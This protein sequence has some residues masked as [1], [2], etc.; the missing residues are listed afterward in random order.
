MDRRKFINR[1][2]AG[3]AG[4]SLA[5]NAFSNNSILQKK[6]RLGVALVGLGYYST[7]LLAPAL[8]LTQRCYLAGIVTGTP[9]KAE[10]WKE[11]YKIPDKN[12]YN[13]SNV[14]SIA[15]NPDIDVVY[16]VL[17]PS[18]H[19]EYSI[20]AARAG[21]HV[22]CEKPMAPSVA[23]CKNMIDA[24]A[25]NKVKLSIGYRMHH[26]PNTQRIIKFRKDLT[27]GKVISATAAAG[28][29]DPRTDHWKQKKSMGGGVMGDMGVYPLNA[30][31]YSV[32]LEPMAV[33]AKASTTR[34]EIY[35][36]VE[37]TM[38]FNLEFPGGATAACEASF[39]KGMS[40]LKVTCEKGWYTLSPFQAY[41]GIN[42]ITSDGIRLNATIPNQQ[43][44]QMDDDAL[45]IID[46]TPVLVPGEEGLKD[47][48]VVEAIYRSAAA[49][50]RVIIG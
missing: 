39:G 9:A 48:I 28:Y 42:G 8:Q 36:E 15:N 19:A 16:V 25:K 20:R 49:N 14:D 22:W 45:A 47:T 26:E 30:A 41:N 11:Q 12:I 3:M 21:K 44:K 2:M 4:I 1:A 33:T 35:K 43:A 6:A 18:M 23:D 10:K 40:D 37:E 31:R 13:Y 46:N 32:G 5:Q 38:V 27:Y 29:F 34:P 7:D 24:C 50:A 17:P